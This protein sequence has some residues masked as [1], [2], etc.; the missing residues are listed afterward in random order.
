VALVA[1]LA[2]DAQLLILDEPTSGLDPLMEA[3]FQQCIGEAAREGRTILL[4][5][6]ILAEVE[7][8]CEVVTII[9]AGRTVQSGTLTELRH[10]TRTTVTATTRRSPDGLAAVPGVHNVKTVDDQD[11]GVTFDVDSEHLDAVMSTL[12]GLGV[13]TITAN[14]PTLEDL[15]LREYSDEFDSLG[16]ERR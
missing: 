11:N 2:A 9:R 14:P 10:L 3:V 15:F 12:A 8:L 16:I 13:V 6:H 1:A 7:S 5:S 4:S